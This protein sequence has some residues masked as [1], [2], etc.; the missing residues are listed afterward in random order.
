MWTTARLFLVLY[1]LVK[2]PSYIFQFCGS[3]IKF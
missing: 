3:P 2:L 1:N